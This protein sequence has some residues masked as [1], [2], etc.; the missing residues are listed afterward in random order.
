MADLRAVTSTICRLMDLEAP[1]NCTKEVLQPVLDLKNHSEPLE[2]C[3]IYNP[4]AVGKFLFSRYSSIFNTVENLTSLK[5]ELNS[6]FPPKT[7]V[8]FASMYSGS[9][10]EYHGITQYEK[11]VLQIETIFDSVVRAGK[12]AAI[13]AVRNSSIDMIFRER[14]IEYYSELYDPLVIRR[15]QQLIR[16][17]EHDLIVVY[18]Q[19]YDDM[20]HRTTPFSKECISALKNHVHSFETIVRTCENHWDKYRRLIAFIPDHG[21]HI[22]PESEKGDHGL[23]I[24]EDMKILS[25]WDI[26]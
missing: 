1:E 26:K 15:A 2:R 6:I 20:L 14:E 17:D 4:D 12:K 9:L 24:D 23:D 22:N 13:V 21:G 8:C 3:L 10:P 7:P 5:L 11:P 25:F 19:E 18:N 16:R